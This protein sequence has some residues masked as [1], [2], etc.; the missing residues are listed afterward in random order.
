[1]AG[2]TPIQAPTLVS[3]NRQS[4]SSIKQSVAQIQANSQ[5]V[6]DPNVSQALNLAGSAISSMGSAIDQILAALRAPIPQPNQTYITDPSGNLIGW[7]GFSSLS[8]VSYKGAWFQNLYVGGTGPQNAQFSVTGNPSTGFSVVINAGSLILENGA[9][10][11]GDGYISLVAVGSTITLNPLTDIISLTV[12]SG[13]EFIVTSAGM[14]VG[15]TVTGANVFITPG[16][17]AVGGAPGLNTT[18]TV[19]SLTSMVFA[20]GILVGYS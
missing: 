20:A 16:G 9:Y 1:M 6:Q 4:P 14:G 2:I 13:F 17:I 10:I 19:A 11:T 18:L 3:P 12:P 5:N 15:N 8:G 7:I